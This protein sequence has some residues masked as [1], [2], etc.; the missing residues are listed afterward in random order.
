MWEEYSLMNWRVDKRKEFKGL[1]L[2]D[3]TE[4]SLTLQ[5]NCD[6]SWQ[7]KIRLGL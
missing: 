4:M 2:V 3:T 6:R 5:K 1:K 7:M